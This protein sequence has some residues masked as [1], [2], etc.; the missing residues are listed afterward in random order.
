M[1]HIYVHG[2]GQVPDCWNPLIQKINI[3]GSCL[4]P[5]LAELLQGEDVSYQTLYQAFSDVCNTSQ[6]PLNLCGLSLGGVLALNY[7]LDHPER[8][9]ALV[10]IS[11][12]YKMPKLLLQFQNLLFRLM[13]NAAFEQIGFRKKAF[14]QLCKTMMH[15]DFSDSLDKIS[16]PTLVICG[17]KDVANK[18][19][20]IRLS[21]MIPHAELQLLEDVG[22]EANVEAPEV[23]SKVIQ[24]YYCSIR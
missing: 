1:K 18:K 6:E 15:L 14:L 2:L 23:L 3:A 5:N 11:T 20:S 13:P 8:I 24:E 10:L 9:N 17:K 16:C 12:K 21:Q 19:A 22:H 7:A 4:C